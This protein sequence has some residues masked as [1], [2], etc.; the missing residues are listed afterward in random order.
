MVISKGWNP[1]RQVRHLQ[2]R[3]TRRR[4]NKATTQA[5]E[6]QL[7]QKGPTMIPTGSQAVDQ[8]NSPLASHHSGTG[9]SV[10]KSH[11]SSQYQVVSRRRKGYKGKTKTSLSQRKKESDPMIQR[12][13]DLVKEVHKSHK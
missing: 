9:R 6:E 10:S 11:H 1:T 7:N 4:E 8:P 12:Q 5:I 2:G 13:L 3:E